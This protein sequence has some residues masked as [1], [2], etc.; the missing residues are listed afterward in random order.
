MLPK[1]HIDNLL[2]IDNLKLY[3]KI[4]NKNPNIDKYCNNFYHRY[5]NG[6]WP[7]EVCFSSNK[8]G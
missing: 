4:R 1:S 2:Y 7:R 3:G 5:N 6:I 8:S